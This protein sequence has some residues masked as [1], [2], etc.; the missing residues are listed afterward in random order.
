MRNSAQAGQEAG[1]A[2][3]PRSPGDPPPFP[4]SGSGTTRVHGRYATLSLTTFVTLNCFHWEI[5]FAQEFAD[6]TAHGDFWRVRIPLTQDW[7][8]RVQGYLD[9]T[10]A[11][12]TLA[13]TYL[14]GSGNLTTDPTAL[15][16]TLYANDGTGAANTAFF[17]GTCWVQRGQV[18]APQAMVTQT[19]ELVAA[20]VP[21]VFF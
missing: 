9:R 6:A 7:T 18:I 19:V 11:A 15:T 10:S 8:G 13:T 21:T 5:D 12:L 4:G 17:T 14:G 2:L 1:I 20:Q 3:L 16:L